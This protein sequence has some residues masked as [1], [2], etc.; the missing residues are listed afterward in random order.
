[1]S[2]Q[3][4]PENTA[5]NWNFARSFPEIPHPFVDRSNYVETIA[6]MLSGDAHV[7]LLEGDEGTGATTIA[8]QFSRSKGNQTFSLFIK[9]VS[10]FSYSLDYL[11]LVLAEQIH[12]HLTGQVFDRDVVDQSEYDLL[13]LRLR[14]KAGGKPFVFVIDGLHQ[15]PRDGSINPGQILLDLL[16]VGID[17]FR[18]LIVGNSEIFTKPL[19]NINIKTFQ[20][21]RWTLPETQ[22][23]LSDLDISEVDANSIFRVC[24]GIAGRIA[25]IKRLLQSG[26][27]LDSILNN[28]LPKYLSFIKLE[29]D[30]AESLTIE[31]KR[32]L[33]ILAYARHEINHDELLAISGCNELDIQ[34]ILSACNFITLSSG[35]NLVSF[36]SEPHR[37][38]TESAL[39]SLKN[40]TIA[41]QIEFLLRD[42]TSSVSVRFLP[43]YYKQAN[44]LRAILQLLSTEH[45][46]QLLKTT[47]SLAALRTRAEL[48]VKTAVELKE[49]ADVF[50]FALQRSIF[51]AVSNFS[52]LKSEVGALVALGQP[53]RALELANRSASQE[54]RL[55]LVAAYANRLK[56]KQ[57]T[58]DP[59]VVKYLRELAENVDFADVD[60]AAAVAADVLSA[61]PDLAMTIIDR[62]SQKSAQPS[63][64]EKALVHLSLSA[65]F[66]KSPDAGEVAEKVSKRISDEEVSRLISSVAAFSSGLSPS[67]II[68]ST[69]KMGI[70]QR[71][72][73]LR[74]LVSS[75]PKTPGAL[76]LVEHGLDQIVK[77]ASYSPKSRDLADLSSPLPFI[78]DD[79][80][81]L[82]ALVSRFDAQ[83]GLIKDRAVSSDVA[84]LQMN[85]ARAE[86]R[87]DTERSCAR[88]EQIYYEV[89][90]QTEAEVKLRCLA[91][92]LQSLSVMDSQ[93]TLESKFHY[94]Q[95]ISSDLAEVL[96]Q[97]LENSAKQ[98][99]VTEGPLR[100]I[101]AFDPK[102]A[103]SIA[104]RLN[105]DERRQIA[106]G[107]VARCISTHVHSEE[108]RAHIEECLSGIS[109]AA[110]LDEVLLSISR[111]LSESVDKL[112]WTAWSEEMLSRVADDRVAAKCLLYVTK[113]KISQ[114]K[115]IDVQAFENQL[116]DY[117]LSVDSLIDKADLYFRAA[118][119]IAS[120]DAERAF[121]LYELA[122]D[123]KRQCAFGS[124]E[125]ENVIRACLSLLSRAFRPII[126]A[127]LFNSDLLDRYS[128]LIDQLPSLALRTSFYSELATKAWCVGKKD[129][130]SQIV[131]RFCR[132]AISGNNPVAVNKSLIATAFQALLCT[133][134]DSALD[135]ISKFERSE[136]DELLYGG[137]L[138]I[139]SKLTSSEP[140]RGNEI[141]KTKMT[142]EEVL[143]VIKI[144][145]CIETDSLLYFLMRQLVKT[146]ASKENRNVFTNQQKADYASKLQ[147]LISKKLPDKLNIS[148]PGFEIAA[149]ALIAQLRQA[150]VQDWSTIKKRIDQ[151]ENI[152]DRALVK[153]NIVEAMPS[154]FRDIQLDL[155]KEALS[156]THRIPTVVD[157][158][159]RLEIYARVASEKSLAP[160]KS[161][162]ENAVALTC[163]VRDQGQA[164]AYRR[165][166]IDLADRIES[167]F[168]EKLA[169]FID[170]DP[171][172]MAAK[173][174]LRKEAKVARIKRDLIQ[175]GSVEI[176]E[177]KIGY[178]PAAAW[179][180][181]CAL[182]AGRLEPQPPDQLLKY[183]V[184][185][186]SLDIHA[187]YPVLSW[188]LENCAR[189]FSTP[190]EVE[191]MI[192][193]LAEALLLSSEM[194]VSIIAKT[195]GRWGARAEVP[196]A[197]FNSTYVVRPD[198][199]D[200]AL[201]FVRTW[202]RRNAKGY[203][204]FCDPYFSPDDVG[205]FRLVLSECP[206]FSIKVLTS[207][208]ELEKKQA[209]LADAFLAQW[210]LECDQEMPEVEVIAIS[211]EQGQGLVH[212]RW[213]L[214][215]GA[216]LRFGTSFNSLGM[217]KLSELSEMDGPTAATYEREVD[218]FLQK[219]RIVNGT[220]IHYLSFTL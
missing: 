67:E 47:Q 177:D 113:A 3:S 193:P 190:A 135:L 57:G 90:S 30:A 161:I 140:T 188:H 76:D 18:F 7:V 116:K 15:I 183:V 66:E 173:E 103:I 14:R 100:A 36:I 12:W 156:D 88:I 69:Q 208:S 38:M 201:L 163:D 20:L 142:H 164:A 178:L 59:I 29:V 195:P 217:Q 152:A 141:E 147:S 128:R 65:S 114:K 9:P 60:S 1:M 93:G 42:P 125:T 145:S 54:S 73:F 6:Q 182:H 148:H 169:D 192:V 55:G 74:T 105:T 220:R 87:Y 215:E 155:L 81:R 134:A 17:K 108:G 214:T 168:S 209:L 150:G 95:M 115:P 123:Q 207:K 117:V 85:L 32:A 146:I 44:E 191:R 107:V 139:I 212:D 106:L 187:A 72:H 112:S 16:P 52:S 28:D 37:K 179:R 10:R 101:A 84:I 189:R 22:L 124:R 75:Q 51:Y 35:S 94:K 171:A 199:R 196:D 45:Y 92:L 184:A 56:K 61:D 157:K 149:L 46:E 79:I 11:R 19:K 82:E 127:G 151:I 198:T 205:L 27:S 48:G 86:Q 203:L 175:R 104:R 202:L 80:S 21:V 33:A 129:L 219:R 91:V 167:G 78:L 218:Q 77:E 8:A 64:A 137:A 181:V 40:E 186:G 210:R 5:E 49:T 83:M 122:L 31:Q 58:I 70:T 43:T 197:G 2:T 172:R 98:F 110:E 131:N 133:H 180:N 99:E 53:Q 24:S 25:S 159:G 194:A 165:S 119:E 144:I 71:I 213:L 4:S 118:E 136:R 200:A 158:V 132:P 111:V 97:V 130:C 206:D 41:R 23:Y 176:S 50:K 102:M 204:K 143:D 120:H 160:V 63:H 153:M 62:A 109:N 166:L 96:N 162:V 13:L 174:E 170:D 26:L 138:L 185:A 34:K 216:G 211:N 121:S 68:S 126:K 89:A 39:S 154:K